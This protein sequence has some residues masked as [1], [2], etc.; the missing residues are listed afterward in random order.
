MGSGPESDMVRIEIIGVQRGRVS[1]GLFTYL[2]MRKSKAAR[3]LG[4]MCER[5]VMRRESQFELGL[6]VSA[7]LNSSNFWILPG[8]GGSRLQGPTLDP[9]GSCSDPCPTYMSVCFPL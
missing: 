9:Q 5:W 8:G 7:C 2:E 3:G 4:R 6:R 1:A